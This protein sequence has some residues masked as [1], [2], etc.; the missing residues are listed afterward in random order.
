MEED[1]KIIST[2]NNSNRPLNVSAIS[3][4]CGVSRMTVKKK[5]VRMLEEGKVICYRLTKTRAIWR[6]NAN[7]QETN[8]ENQITSMV[9]FGKT[10][11]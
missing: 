7:I 3:K 1:K 8:I 5:L 2:L 11:L 6:L 10:V 9:S 4:S